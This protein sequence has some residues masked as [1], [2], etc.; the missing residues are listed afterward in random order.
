MARNPQL[1]EAHYYKAVTYLMTTPPDT[2]RAVASARA[3][4]SAGFPRAEELLREAEAKARG[5]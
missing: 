3:A 1:G 4:R 5:E 2:A